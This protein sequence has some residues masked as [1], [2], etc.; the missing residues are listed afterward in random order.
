MPSSQLLQGSSQLRIK[1]RTLLA[2]Q[3]NFSPRNNLSYFVGS[4]SRHR[5]DIPDI[6]A[7]LNLGL[8]V[9]A[10][11]NPGYFLTRGKPYSRSIKASLSVNMFCRPN[12][13]DIECE[14]SQKSIRLANFRPH[15]NE[16]SSLAFSALM[17]GRIH[18]GRS[19]SMGP[20]QFLNLQPA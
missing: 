1:L 8:V 14:V 9:I 2:L 18:T 3:L 19:I 15:P 16:A 12:T 5:L 7:L 11:I 13:T 10:A 6:S 4:S 17:D 20:G